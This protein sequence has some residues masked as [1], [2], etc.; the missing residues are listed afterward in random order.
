MWNIIVHEDENNVS[1]SLEHKLQRKTQTLEQQQNKVLS[2]IMPLG[3]TI[4]KKKL[5]SVENY[6]NMKVSFKRINGSRNN[7]QMKIH[8]INLVLLYD[9]ER[10]KSPR[11]L[12][13]A[14]YTTVVVDMLWN[15][16]NVDHTWIQIKSL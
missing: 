16:S 13:S 12:M 5:F 8:C 6:R 4:S 3:A 11:R 9:G 2:S 14:N 10:L 15:H 1:V 7:C